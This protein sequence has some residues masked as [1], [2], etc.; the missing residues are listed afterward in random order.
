MWIVCGHSASTSL[1]TIHSFIIVLLIII[2]LE[3]NVQNK[4]MGLAI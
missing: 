1:K 4:G 2:K 3:I